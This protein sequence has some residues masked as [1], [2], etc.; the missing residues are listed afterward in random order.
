MNKIY[1][2]LNVA[3]LAVTSLF[4]SAP[5]ASAYY[6]P[7]MQRWLT[8]DP[9]YE[10]GGF[11]L[12]R[13]VANSCPNSFDLW[14]ED[15][16]GYGGGTGDQNNPPYLPPMAAPPDDTTWSEFLNTL[17]DPNGY[18]SCYAKCMAGLKSGADAANELGG[19][20]I[21]AS[22][23]Y[24]L[25]YPHWFKAGGRYSKVL[26]PRL[27]SRLTVAGLLTIPC[28]I[29]DCMSKCMNGDNNENQSSPPSVPP[30]TGG[31]VNAPPVSV[32][33]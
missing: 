18:T 13:F 8:R 9:I 22:Y 15:I 30:Y 5:T 25:K 6:D 12:Y 7:G 33:N 4:F 23:Y 11:N 20:K 3:A 21:A 17:V 28:D 10:W 26:I 29:I 14:G 2:A 27:A 19:N 31:P 32:A 24:K 16:S 1:S